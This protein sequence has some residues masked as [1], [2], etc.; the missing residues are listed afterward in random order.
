MG[1]GAHRPGSRSSGARGIAPPTPLKPFLD[2]HY[3]TVQPC[4]D[5]GPSDQVKLPGIAPRLVVRPPTLL[6]RG[7]RYVM[8]FTHS[9]TRWGSQK[10][11]DAFFFNACHR[12]AYSKREHVTHNLRSFRIRRSLSPNC[13]PATHCVRWPP[14]TS[15]KTFKRSSSSLVSIHLSGSFIPP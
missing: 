12:Y 14:S 9:S 2:T 7:L 10:A 15:C 13:C 4:P 5:V 3:P 1:I 11:P 8:A 6:H